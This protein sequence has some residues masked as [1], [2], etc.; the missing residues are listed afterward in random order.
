VVDGNGDP[1]PD[2]WTAGTTAPLDSALANTYLGANN[3]F[4]DLYHFRYT[5]TNSTLDRII[6]FAITG[7]AAQTFDSLASSSGV[8]GPAGI[9]DATV[10]VGQGLDFHVIVPAP[11]SAALLGLGGLMAARRRRTA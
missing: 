8:W 11:A 10:N 1:V 4:V 9:T 7:A 2:S 3:N 5:I 6:H